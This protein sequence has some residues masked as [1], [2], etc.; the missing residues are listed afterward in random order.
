MHG[1]GW[2][3]FWASHG[4]VPWGDSRGGVSI[5]GVSTV[6]TCRLGIRLV[7]GKENAQDI[8]GVDTSSSQRASER[9]RR[10]GSLVLDTIYYPGSTQNWLSVGIPVLGLVK[11][12]RKAPKHA[13]KANTIQFIQFGTF[14]P[15]LTT[16][17]VG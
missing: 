8:C 13:S 12:R 11:A 7:R 15:A 10:F 4:G 5:G 3:L 2:V 9:A 16:D 14:C 17:A 6:C 1:L